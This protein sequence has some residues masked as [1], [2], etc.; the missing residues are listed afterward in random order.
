MPTLLE[1][2]AQR[3]PLGIFFFWTT[4]QTAPSECKPGATVGSAAL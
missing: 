4:L 1:Q 3:P 2:G